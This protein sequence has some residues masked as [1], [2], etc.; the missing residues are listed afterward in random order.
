MVELETEI[1]LKFVWYF[2]VI[3]EIENSPVYLYL[4]IVSNLI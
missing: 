4:I 2:L 3:L 1:C